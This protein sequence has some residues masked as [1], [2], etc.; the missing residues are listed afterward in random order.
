MKR[1]F[2]S[3]LVISF[4]FKLFADEQFIGV[5]QYQLKRFSF[6]GDGGGWDPSSVR[7]RTFVKDLQDLASV[8]SSLGFSEFSAQCQDSGFSSE[9]QN[10]FVR[11]NLPRGRYRGPSYCGTQ[12]FIRKHKLLASYIS[13]DS[14]NLVVVEEEPNPTRCVSDKIPFYLEIYL[15]N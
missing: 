3:L 7:C 12:T 10:A 14:L 15:N 4:S 6:I 11:S 5:T 8:R 2:L 1:I 13:T 9:L